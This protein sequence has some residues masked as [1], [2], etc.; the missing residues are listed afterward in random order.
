MQQPLEIQQTRIAMALQL[1]LPVGGRANALI[2]PG[3][4]GLQH[5]RQIVVVG[6]HHGTDGR[7][8]L[9]P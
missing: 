9:R 7:E 3:Q 5:P 1:A 2:E 6:G 4:F 8:T